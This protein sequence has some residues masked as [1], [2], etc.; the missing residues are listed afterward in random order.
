M[1]HI[2]CRHLNVLKPQNAVDTAPGPH[3]I[4]HWLI[5]EPRRIP[6]NKENRDFTL[7][8]VTPGNDAEGVNKVSVGNKLLFT[9]QIPLVSF[10][11]TIGLNIIA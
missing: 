8:P 5:V 11:D 4:P 1:H 2:L 3:G 6:V 9:I 10:S 7:I